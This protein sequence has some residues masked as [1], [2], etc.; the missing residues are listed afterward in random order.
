MTTATI[1]HYDSIRRAPVRNA[2]GLHDLKE[3]RVV[4]THTDKAARAVIL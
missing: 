4:H 2:L 3:L 1:W